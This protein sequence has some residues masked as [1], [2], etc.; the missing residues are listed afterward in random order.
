MSVRALATFKRYLKDN[1]WQVLLF[2]AGPDYI[3][4][5]MDEYEKQLEGI[6]QEDDPTAPE[7]L[8][9]QFKE[10]LLTTLR[11][12]TKWEGDKLQLQIVNFEDL[13]YD[14]IPDSRDTD[15]L[16]TFVFI[17][18]GIVG[19]YA[20]IGEDFYIE[21]KREF[22]E[23]GTRVPGQRYGR[24][25]M[26]YLIEKERFFREGWDKFGAFEVFK[27]GFSNQGPKDIFDAA[28]KRFDWEP[29]YDK[30]IDMTIA[31]MKKR[32]F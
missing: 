9:E 31:D 7:H 18:E 25:G 27:W 12:D 30:A 29:Y 4:I 17:L 20:W 19:E 16:K 3:D 5:I 23:M 6:V 14:N 10:K 22:P 13:G 1:L 26:G 32:G 15:L 8:K 11:F 24:V 21:R 2:E 28:Q